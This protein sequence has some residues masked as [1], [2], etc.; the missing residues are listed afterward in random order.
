M[1]MPDH[2][3]GPDIMEPE[4]T[5]SGARVGAGLREVRERLGWQL[6]D[7]AEGLRIRPEFLVAI[8]AGDLSSLPGTAYRTGFVRSYAQALG[9]DGEEILRRFRDAGQLGLAEKAEIQ[10]L[11][12]V[13]DRGVPKGAIVLIGI[14]LVVA[15]YGLWYRHT[16]QQRQLDQ[17]VTHVP[18]ELQPL[19]TPPKVTPPPVESP[20]SPAT[21]SQP[22]GTKPTAT[23]PAGQAPAGQAPATPSGTA[24]QAPAGQA[25]A[26]QAAAE[27]AAAAPSGPASSASAPAAAS[28]PANAAASAPA[29]TQGTEITATQDAWVQVT[30][31]AGNILFSKVLHPGES[32]PV[33]DMPGLKMTTGNAGGTLLTTNGQAGQPLGAPGVVLHGYQLTPPAS[34]TASAPASAGTSPASSAA[35]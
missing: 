33:P 13:P 9:L 18:A 16:E 22:S 23:P 25:P 6:P 5:S 14:V 1:D 27:Q 29:A 8:E 19:A 17:S 26:G 12:P 2:M 28:V 7:V 3:T 15:G 20:Q 32:W 4:S 30:D 35:Q 34:G 31:P 10:F 11:A 24:G 21:P